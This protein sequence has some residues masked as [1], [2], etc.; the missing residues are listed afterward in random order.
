MK[1]LVEMYT[2]FLIITKNHIIEQ[3]KLVL[4]FTSYTQIQ[5]KNIRNSN[6]VN[7]HVKRF[8]LNSFL[9]IFH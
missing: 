2:S 3:F 8:Y 7:L 6:V 4:C 1:L 5:L 9:Y